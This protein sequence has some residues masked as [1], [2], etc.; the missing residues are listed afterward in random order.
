[1]SSILSAQ[2]LQTF[3]RRKSVRR[4]PCALS[5]VFAPPRPRTARPRSSLSESP[6]LNLPP[7]EPIVLLVVLVRGRPSP[8]CRSRRQPALHAAPL[9]LGL[10]LRARPLDDLLLLV[11]ADDE[12]P[13]DL[14][15]SPCS[16]RSSL[17]HQLARPVDHLEDV[18]AFLVVADLVRQPAASPVLGLLDLPVQRATDRLR[19]ARAD[20]RPAARSPRGGGCR[21]VRTV[22]LLI[23]VSF[24]TSAMPGFSRTARRPPAGGKDSAN[25]RPSDRP[26]STCLTSH[27]GLACS[28]SLTPSS[29]R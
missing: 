20:R 22:G 14:V 7:V 15:A 8:G 24:W 1:M 21:R 26:W 28:S 12:M 18:D 11:H 4:W 6:W 29:P 3:R 25:G 17:L 19:P 16:R 27:S 2:N 5:P 23:R 9:G 13:D 10:A